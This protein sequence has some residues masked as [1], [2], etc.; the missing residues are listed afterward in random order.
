[1]ERHHSRG[2]KNGQRRGEQ[3]RTKNHGD[4]RRKFR[5]RK[6]RHVRKSLRSALHV[7]LAHCAVRL[8]ERRL[9]SQHAR[10]N[11]TEATRARRQKSRRKTEKGIVRFRPRHLRTPNRSAVRRRPPLGR[12]HHRSRPHARRLDLGSRSRRAQSR[13]PRVQDRSSANVSFSLRRSTSRR[14]RIFFIILVTPLL[15]WMLNLVCAICFDLLGVLSSPWAE[16]ICGHGG[17]LPA[18][19]FPVLR[20]LALFSAVAIPFSL[21]RDWRVWKQT[22]IQ[23]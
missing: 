13:N 5:R 23:K 12:R 15:I 7:C 21:F 22:S 17:F 11:Q 16:R 4:L 2:R 19:L 14:T 3:R 6:L 8:Y 1:M 10:Q 9:R 20:V 18:I